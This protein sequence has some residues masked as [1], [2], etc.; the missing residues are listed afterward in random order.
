[1]KT[2]IIIS[3]LL[4]LIVTIL[5]VI[6]ETTRLDVELTKEQYVNALYRILFVNR[7]T[8]NCHFLNV[9]S[10]DK[11]GICPYGRL[12][13]KDPFGTYDILENAVNMAEKDSVSLN[14]T[15]GLKA[16]ILVPRFYIALSKEFK[17][18]VNQKEFPHYEK[19]KIMIEEEDFEGY[20][21][22]FYRED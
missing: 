19:V 13:D 15:P 22:A 7:R 14:G 5:Y 16:L 10:A 12:K 21:N 9:E 18:A 4:F 11:L 6:K 3:G 20:I 17:E 8:W 1:M 2:F